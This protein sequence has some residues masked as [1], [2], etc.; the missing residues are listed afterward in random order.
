MED[1]KKITT[2]INFKNGESKIFLDCRE[3]M[4]L[5]EDGDFL[6][7]IH[8]NYKGNTVISFYKCTDIGSFEIEYEDST[9]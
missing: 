6:K 5:F 3:H 2:R 9:I 7:V 1:S 4:D 8:K